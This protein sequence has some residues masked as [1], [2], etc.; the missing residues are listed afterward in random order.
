[1]TGALVMVDRFGYVFVAELGE[2][3]AAR[4]WYVGPGRPLGFKLWSGQLLVADSLKGLLSL[5]LQTGQLLVLANRASDTG[6]VIN[7]C[8]DLDVD[9]ETGDVF[10]T[11]STQ[12]PVAY[13][14]ARG[15][16]DTMLCYLLDALRGARSGR[17]LR[18][19]AATRQTDTLLTDLAYAN[20]VALSGDASFVAVAET[21]RAR[22]LK[23]WLAGPKRGETEVLV[24]DLPGLPD[25]VSRASDGGFW[26]ALV[27]PLSPLL[28]TLA[29][30][31]RLRTLASHF[32]GTFLQRHTRRAPPFSHKVC[33]FLLFLL[34]LAPTHPEFGTTTT[35]VRVPTGA[36]FPLIAKKW[37][38]VLKIDE[39]GAPADALFDADGA[40]VSSVSAVV[41]H[42][43]RLFLGNLNG[44]FVSVIDL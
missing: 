26:I 16:Y 6:D 30:Y 33:V 9:L 21:N 19:S 36:V 3:V 32:V 8:N 20:G 29:P 5:D 22:V 18:Y 4:R 31:P 28:K 24:R 38:A 39:T 44:D 25:G 11:S 1:M 23:H 10:F 13:D 17:L 14:G 35:T 27:A 15:F 41:Q 34:T 42:G 2:T 37:G 43:D 12:L 40:L 7:Y